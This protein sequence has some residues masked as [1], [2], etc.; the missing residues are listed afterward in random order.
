MK[1]TRVGFI[2][3]GDLGAP[4]ARRI[5]DAGWPLCIYDIRPEALAPFAGTEASVAASPREVGERSDIAG[6]CVFTDAQVVDV[7]SGSEGLLGGMS[8]GGTIMVH[9]T[10]RAETCKRVADD[11]S[12]RGVSLIEAAVGNGRDEA[13]AGQLPVF[14][15]GDPETVDR[16][17]PVMES[18]AKDV[19]WLGPI[20]AGA[21]SKLVHNALAY[22]TMKLIDDAFSFGA[23]LGLDRRALAEVLLS[24]ANDSAIL[25]RYTS[26]L[27]VEG[28]FTREKLVPHT[29]RIRDQLMDTV[30]ATEADAHQL[31]PAVDALIEMIRADSYWRPER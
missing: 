5:M 13:A 31:A 11:A 17:R 30:R 3:L 27:S 7:V 20:G 23:D 4:M 28:G 2:G 22:A 24:G 21:N 18:F 14:A 10:V 15:G 25:R 8:P 29:T 1:A 9:S 6:V 19:L 26:H 12:V 16:C